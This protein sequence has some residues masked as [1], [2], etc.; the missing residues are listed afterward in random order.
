MTYIFS[1]GSKYEKKSIEQ[2]A[3][4]DYLHLI[5]LL[6][7]KYS[8][9]DLKKNIHDIT[10]KLNNFIPISPC[11]AC[12]KDSEYFPMEIVVG[13]SYDPYK[14]MDVTKPLD[15]IKDITD[16]RCKEHA[17]NPRQRGLSYVPT[18]FDILRS[19]SNE[20]KW[21]IEKINEA[22]LALSGFSG[23]RTK[24]NCEYFLEN[25][26]QRPPITKPQGMIEVIRH[27]G[28]KPIQPELF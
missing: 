19:Y 13:T 9:D 18:K 15:V 4:T 6:E 23:S 2:V 17:K 14:G 20:P 7:Y 24:K 26:K 3:L 28:S 25:L 8:G 5:G 1:N 16:L 11:K 21:V 12:G 27:S 10:E 22:L